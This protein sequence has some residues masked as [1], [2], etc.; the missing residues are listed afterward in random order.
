V[1]DAAERFTQRPNDE[2]MR[3]LEVAFGMEPLFV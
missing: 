1:I 3:K 2:Q